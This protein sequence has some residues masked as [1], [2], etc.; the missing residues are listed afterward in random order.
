MSAME[1]NIIRAFA[2]RALQVFYKHEN[3]H[4]MPDTDRTQDKQPQK[5]NDKPRVCSC[6]SCYFFFISSFMLLLREQRNCYCITV[7]GG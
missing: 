7:S 2:G 5:P 6:L 3:E 4:L 1:V